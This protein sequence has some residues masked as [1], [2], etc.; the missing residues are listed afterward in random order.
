[1]QFRLSTFLLAVVVFATSL[2]LTGPW[3]IPFAV[4][5]LL[6]VGFT[7][8]CVSGSGGILGACLVWFLGVGLPV[9]IEP[10]Y[11]HATPAALRNVC[12]NNLKQIALG[13]RDYRTAFSC[14]PPP[15]LPDK[16]GKPMHS[17]RVLVLPYLDHD[18]LYRRYRFNEPWN[19]P[20]NSKLA[21]WLKIYVCPG[22]RTITGQPPNATNYVA[23]TGTGTAWSS[24]ISRPGKP[25]A[26][27]HRVV[28]VEVENSGIPWMEPR[29]LTVDE[30]IAGL[31]SK[32]GPRISSGHDI[33]LANAV[34]ADG[35]VVELP[36][37]LSPELLR[38][39][40]CQ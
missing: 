35:E 7:R 21:T 13:L 18:D 27:D 30:A 9:L 8:V 29:D 1:M 36:T 4:Y 20:N 37:N 17:W 28:L 10:T 38:I 25:I 26:N 14:L 39:G 40:T 31:T 3:G 15:L 24:N 22:D 23:V 32:S 11:S 34:L 19:G 16:N 12:S 6:L 5:V 33:R 2:S